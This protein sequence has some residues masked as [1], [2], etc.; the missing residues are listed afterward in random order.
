MTYDTTGHWECDD[1]PGQMFDSEED[2]RDALNDEL[3]EEADARFEDWIDDT[4]MAHQVWYLMANHHYD[5][6]DFFDECTDSIWD[7]TPVYEGEAAAVLEHRFVWISDTD[8]EDDDDD[9]E[10]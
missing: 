8:T 6:L 3:W 2:I 9:E 4:Y 1:F 5:V 7:E 10:D